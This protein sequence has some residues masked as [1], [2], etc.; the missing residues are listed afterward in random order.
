MAQISDLLQAFEGAISLGLIMATH[1]T[2]P[3]EISKNIAT[4]R[5]AY[6]KQFRQMYWN[7]GVQLWMDTLDEHQRL[8]SSCLSKS[9]VIWQENKNRTKKKLQ[10]ISEF[11]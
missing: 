4:K 9:R 11:Y 5:W 6:K 7:D 3:K 2:G 8:I 10:F 1:D